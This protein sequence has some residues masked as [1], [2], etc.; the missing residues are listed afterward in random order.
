[1]KK[2]ISGRVYDTET[3]QWVVKW[4]NSLPMSDFGWTE[5]TLYQKKTKEYFLHGESGP[6]GKYAKCNED[7][8]IGYGEDII[9]LTDDEV[10]EW[11]SKLG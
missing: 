9:P 8:S 2:R 7:N 4:S 3:A 1:M 6:M 10:E 11:L 5:E